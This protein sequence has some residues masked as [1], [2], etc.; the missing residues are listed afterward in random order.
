MEVEWK[1]AEWEANPSSEVQ[2]RIQAALL[3]LSAQGAPCRL[4]GGRP[5]HY[6]VLFPPS[7]EDQAKILAPAGKTSI[8]CYP[9]CSACASEAGADERTWQGIVSEF[10]RPGKSPE[11]NRPAGSPRRCRPQRPG[12]RNN[13]RRR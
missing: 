4:C 8:L 9:L 6:R 10:A 13:G 7:P 1:W 2:A 12:R 3:L 5:D 11:R